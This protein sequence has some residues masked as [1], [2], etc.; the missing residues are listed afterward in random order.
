MTA[1]S[2]PEDVLAMTAEEV[3]AIVPN[4]RQA[5]ANAA[6]ALADA[7]ADPGSVTPA[8]LAELHAAAEHTA[9]LIP[10]AERRTDEIRQAQHQARREAARQR[11]LTQGPAELDAA[12]DLIAKLDVLDAALRDFCT[13]AYAHNERV[14]AWRQEAR[15]GGMAVDPHTDGITI[16]SKTWRRMEGGRL[17][18]S[19][20]YRAMHH[21]PDDFQRTRGQFTITHYGDPYGT[22]RMGER[23]V[24]APVAD[25]DLHDLIRKDA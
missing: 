21:Y 1:T 5:A 8:K 24:S 12:D 19:L 11:V 13:A 3:A 2:P 17:I 23:M 6:R 25:L 18:E 4:A 7:K 15:A 20:V 10:V 9:L 16:G 22:K 14:E